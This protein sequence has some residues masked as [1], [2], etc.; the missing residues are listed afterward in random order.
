[1]RAAAVDDFLAVVFFVAVVA[2]LVLD[3]RAAG[4]C[5]AAVLPVALCAV[6]VRVAAFLL[7]A[8]VAGDFLAVVVLAGVFLAA[9]FLAGADV[10]VDVLAVVFRAVDFLAGAVFAVVFLAAVF[11]AGALDAVFFAGALDAAALRAGVFADLFAAPGVPFAAVLPPDPEAFLGGTL[12]P[13]LRASDRPMARAWRG[14]VTLRPLLLLSWPC[15]YSCMTSPTFSCV[16]L[17]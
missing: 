11:F 1:M 3:L 7:G 17:P 13:S 5:A 15:L 6:D 9:V 4:L 16:F 10:A 2:L 14:L 8:L 12:S